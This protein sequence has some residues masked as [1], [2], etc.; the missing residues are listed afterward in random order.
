MT[1]II[2]QSRDETWQL[3][4]RLGT[5]A[6]PG[7]FIA[8]GGDLGAGKTVFAKG[9][10]AGLS[11]SSVVSSP[12]FILVALHESGRLPLWHVDAYRLTAGD[13]IDGLGLEEADDGVVVMEWATRF[14]NALPNDRLEVVLHERAGAPDVREIELI[15]TGPRHRA[16]VEGVV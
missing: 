2:S 6:V 15:A 11:V 3:G 4:E 10:G 13:E 1:R 8:L 12:T 5:L 7:T 14:P 9:V 16:L